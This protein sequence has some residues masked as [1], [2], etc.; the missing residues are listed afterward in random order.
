MTDRKRMKGKISRLA[1]R[2]AISA[3]APDTETPIAPAPIAIP[4]NK[5]DIS[6]IF[7]G[8]QLM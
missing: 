2:P 5:P 1:Y 7:V 6:P 3:T 4:R 8:I